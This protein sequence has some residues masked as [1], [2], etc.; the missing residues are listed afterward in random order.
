MLVHLYNI[1]YTSAQQRMIETAVAVC[2]RKTRFLLQ[3]IKRLRSFHPSD[4]ALYNITS[5]LVRVNNSLADRV[6]RNGTCDDI[7]FRTFIF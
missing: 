7:Y 5:E 6:N 4:I 3:Y 2:A 1:M